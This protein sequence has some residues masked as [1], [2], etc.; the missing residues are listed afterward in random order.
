VVALVKDRA[1]SI[2]QLA[3]EAMLFYSRDVPKA[4]IP[5]DALAALSTLKAK[6]EKAPWEK[7]AISEA[8]KQVL[9]ESGL[10]MPQLAMPLRQAVTGRTQTPSIDAVL[11]LLGRETV[12]ARLAAQLPNG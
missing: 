9:K 11:E 7:A 2:P 12:L 5:P 4:Q 8:M 10:K 6:L 3:D 1:N